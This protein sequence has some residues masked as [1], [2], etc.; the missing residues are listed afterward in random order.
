MSNRSIESVIDELLREGRLSR[1]GFVGRLGAGAFAVSGAAGLLSAC[2]GVQGTGQTGPTATTASHPAQKLTEIDFSNWPLYID[3]DSLPEF[4][5]EFDVT[6]NYV[7]DIND[8]N[9]FFGKVR[10]QLQRDQSIDRDLVVLTDWMAARWVNSGYVEAIDKANVA[11]VEAN[12]IATLRDP[13]WDPG[14][15]FSAP[16][17]AGM[18]GL[19]YNKAETGRELTSFNDIFLP[20]FKGRVS[21]LGEWRDSVGLTLQGMGVNTEEATLDDA[22]AA[23]EKID[24][25]NASGQIRRFTGNDYTGD[26]TN[27]NL[28]IAVAYSGDVIQLKADNPDLEFL[29]PDEGGLIWADNMMIPEKAEHPYGAEVLMNYVYEPEIAAQI[30]AYVNYVTPVAGAQAELEK[31]DP[32]LA[33]NQ[34]IFPDEETLAKLHPFPSLATD[35]ER[36]VEE[37]WQQVV[38]A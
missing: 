21:F 38:G 32:D 30:A 11:N 7:D 34:L 22:M 35:E 10:E 19:G 13:A 28:A 27:G 25:A 17:Q 31:T 14:R 37:A 36:Q 29:I 5:R 20:E 6:V 12:L 8:N 33:S 3:K 1:R 15:N 18:D 2:G 26:L 16:W 23:L 24:Q 4:E 9:E